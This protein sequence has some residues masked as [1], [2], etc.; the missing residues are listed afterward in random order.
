MNPQWCNISKI[1]FNE[2]LGDGWLNAVH[3]DD[4]VPLAMGWQQSVQ[5]Q[6][7]SK[8][9]YRFIRPDGSIAWVSGMAV[10]QKDESGTIVGYIGTTV[11]ITERKQTESKL[12]S[13]SGGK[14][15][16]PAGSPPPG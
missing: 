15:S 13:T 3:P 7:A 1:P 8:A 16:T 12:R 4:R 14:G 9:A 2:A 10:P 11:D 6:A 5:D